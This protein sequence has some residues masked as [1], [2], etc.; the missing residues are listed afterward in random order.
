MR[1]LT[2]LSTSIVETIARSTSPRPERA[3]AELGLTAG[4]LQVAV[5][6]DLVERRLQEEVEGLGQVHR[7]ARQRVVVVVGDDQPALLLPEDVELDHVDA[8]LDRRVEAPGRVS[9][10][11]ASAPLWPMRL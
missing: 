1:S 3:P 2:R 9:L 11:I 8:D 10:T 5:D 4:E 7:L 6:L